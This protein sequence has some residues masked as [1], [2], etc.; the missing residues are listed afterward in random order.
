MNKTPFTWYRNDIHSGMSFVPEI[1]SYCIDMIK[2]TGSASREVLAH[3]VLLC[4]RSDTHALLAPNYKEQQQIMISLKFSI[5]LGV[6]WAKSQST[7]PSIYF[8]IRGLQSSFLLILFRYSP[9]SCSEKPLQN[10][11]KN[12]KTVK[13]DKN[14]TKQKE[15]KYIRFLEFKHHW[16]IKLWGE[17]DRRC[18]NNFQ[19]SLSGVVCFHL[20]RFK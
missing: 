4:A 16:S 11:A 15:Q 8:H 17:S 14:K 3:V 18:K 9:I 19:E 5:S 1:S 12:L 10:V 20:D 7:L 2:L 6:R 13:T